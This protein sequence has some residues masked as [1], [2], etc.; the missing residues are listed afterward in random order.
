MPTSTSPTS[1]KSLLTTHLLPYLT[2]SIHHLLHLRSLYPLRAF[3]LTRAYNYPVYQCRH[4]SVCEWVSSA[5]E[6]IGKEILRVGG[7]GVNGMK[8]VGVVI[9]VAEVEGEG[10]REESEGGRMR[11]REKWVFDISGLPKVPVEET[12]TEFEDAPDI[13]AAGA[14]VKEVEIEEQFR[15]ALSRMNTAARRLRKLPVG[16]SS[17]SVV[18]EFDGKEGGG[19]QGNGP[20]SSLEKSRGVEGGEWIVGEAESGGDREDDVKGE[21]GG[22]RRR[23]GGKTVPIR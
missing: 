10:D 4:P 3:L 18:L 2:V 7:G 14:G 16:K 17:F 19:E 22:N 6:A 1:L 12:R 9:F 15:A 23:R 5:V 11:V 8:R 20:V 21:D 13:S